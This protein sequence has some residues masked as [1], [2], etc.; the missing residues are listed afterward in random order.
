MTK[1]QLPKL[2]ERLPKAIPE[3]NLMKLWDILSNPE[4]SM[5]YA[6]MRDHAMLAVL[7]GCGLRR[8]ELIA[9]RWVDIDR[10]RGLLRVTGKG[11]KWR[12][13]PLEDRMLR[14]LEALRQQTE[15]EFEAVGD[16]VFLTDGGKPCYPKFVYNKVVS[17]LGQVTT[18]AKR[19]PHTLRHSMATHLMDHGAALQG[20]KE[21]LGHSSLAATQVYTHNSITRLKEVYKQAHPGAGK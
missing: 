16:V 5:T 9:M 6:G 8:S 18:A 7:Y 19:S 10:S 21:V 3:S 11:R 15:E 4:I 14:I 17:M 20:V 13:V 12:Q 2:P 1:V